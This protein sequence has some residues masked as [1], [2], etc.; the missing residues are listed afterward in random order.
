MRASLHE[1]LA[2][3]NFALP[4]MPLLAEHL[5]TEGTL[6]DKV[7]GWHCHLTEITAIAAVALL[8][9]GAKLFMSECNPETTNA[10]SVDYMREKGAVIY[11][12]EDS[13]A[14]VLEA[15]PRV[16]SDT[17]LVLT[18]AYESLH[19]DD[20]FVFAASEITTSGITAL[21]ELGESTLPV[22]DINNSQL[23]TFVENYHGVA[24]GV[25]DLLAQVTGKLWTGHDVAIVGYGIVGRGVAAYLRRAGANVGIVENGPVR[26]LIAHYDG[27][28]LD[29][30]PQALAKCSLIITA[31]GQPR[32]LG[33]REWMQARDGALFVNVGHWATELDI[34]SLNTMA[35]S[36]REYAPFIKEYTLKFGKRIYVIAEG[37]PANVV[38]LT[39]SPEPTLIHLTTEILCMNY[40][41]D[42][43]S[44]GEQLS[45]GVHAVPASVER[46][47]AEL[48]LKALN[49]SN[50]DNTP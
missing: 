47:A 21:A 25:M 24:D 28:R 37:G 8:D 34:D 46:S 50:F 14:R 49:L 15:R 33:E 12:N 36:S 7:I 13:P 17:G 40:L 44:R 29:T 19:A 26:N 41:L 5:T 39:G 1:E 11:C 38:T 27:Y 10:D 18:R 22:I 16:I 31:T 48:A 42:L 4:V 9:A 30:L 23:K 43:D 45:P 2:K 35:V 6:K 3:M 20:R 32:V